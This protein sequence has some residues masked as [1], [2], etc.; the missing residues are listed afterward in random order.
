MLA[1]LYCGAVNAH[2]YCQSS[3]TQSTI[4]SESVSM[5]EDLPI[6]NELQILPTTQPGIEA[7]FGDQLSID[8]DTLA[9]G[10][11]DSRNGSRGFVDIFYLQNGLWQHVKTLRSPLDLPGDDFRSVALDGNTLFVG[12]NGQKLVYVY[13]R[14]EGGTD[15]WGLVQQLDGGFKTPSVFGLRPALDGNTA[16]VLD[17][18]EAI[19]GL[20]HTGAVYIFEKGFFEPGQWGLVKRLES[21]DTMGFEQGYSGDGLKLVGDTL[22]Q[23]GH[24]HSGSAINEFGRNEGGADNWGLKQQLFFPVTSVK[25]SAY[26]GETL[27]LHIEDDCVPQEERKVYLAFYNRD[28]GGQWAEQ[29]KFEIDD[30]FRHHAVEGQLVLIGARDGTVGYLMQRGAEPDSWA[31]KGKLMASDPSMEL[32]VSRASMDSG[33]AIIGWPDENNRD[34]MALYYE[35]ARPINTGQMGAWFYPATSGQGQFIDIQPD[36]NYM[37]LSWFTYTEA[38]SDNPNQQ[39]WYTA[40]GH[41]TGNRAELT[42]YETLGGQFDDSQEVTTKGVGEVTLNFTDC[43]S[44]QLIYRFDNEERQGSFPLQRAI[45][46]SENLCDEIDQ[47]VGVKKGDRSTTQAVDINRGMDGAWYEPETSGQGFFVDVHTNLEGSNFIFVSWFTYGDDTA[48]GQRWLTAQGEFSGSQASISVYETTGGSFDDPV[49]V[50]TVE[51]GTMYID[52]TDCSTAQLDYALTND[53][54]SGQIDL[55]R[56]LPGSQ[57]LCEN[58]S[59]EDA[60]LDGV[61]DF[62]DKCPLTPFGEPVDAQGCSESQL[63][64]VLCHGTPSTDPTVQG[65]PSVSGPSVTKLERE[66]QY[67]NTGVR[68]FGS[69]AT[70]PDHAQ[71]AVMVFDDKVYVAYYG[72][73]GELK[74]ARKPLAGCVWTTVTLPYTQTDPDAHRSANIAVSPNDRRIH[75]IWGLHADTLNYVVSKIDNAVDVS[76]AEFNADLFEPRRDHLNPGDDLGRVTYP[77][78]IV[79]NSDNLLVFWRRGGSGGGDTYVSE[80][81]NGSWSGQRG[82]IRGTSGEDYQGSTTRNAYL[83][84]VTSNGGQLH[85][86]WTWRETSGATSNHDL[87]HAYSIDNA[88]NW[89]NSFGTVVGTSGPGSSKINLNS[90]VMFQEVR[91]GTVAN[92]CGQTMT[93]DGRVHVIHRYDGGYQYHRWGPDAGENDWTPALDI[94]A[95]GGRPRIYAGPG[96]SLW[97]VG[98]NG[99][100]IRI[101][102][103][104]RGSDNWGTWNRVYETAGSARYVSSTGYVSG[105]KLVIL[106]QREADDPASAEHTEIEVLTFELSDSPQ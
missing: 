95:N 81:R 31:F 72:R 78:F 71:D 34:G 80:Y 97:V 49:L 4:Q 22:L 89:L 86:T 68:E 40:Q 10:N 21:S 14:D 101:H 25:Y 26:D 29:L 8:G 19:P 12:A 103:A 45:P 93:S 9:V 76:D 28:P 46:G 11:R 33:R 55:V 106:A 5:W 91:D 27:V 105:N 82:V 62:Q 17:H 73:D 24:D 41:Y 96:D 84:T 87:M 15:N 52:F 30:S 3:K 23:Y 7:R 54:L 20:G 42:L 63:D 100:R 47:P 6:L 16:A 53:G 44:G 61:A 37:F 74:I 65:V 85:L 83:N 66:G 92:Q 2:D 36:M 94:G 32:N 98:T 59:G 90:D 58:L 13:E 50:N 77:R 88:V 1:I 75:I 39:Q 35:L 104:A 51:I 70:G 43:Q 102:A 79:G 67:F 69:T 99:K 64:P 48:S 56:A 60:D 38:G 18:E 57:A